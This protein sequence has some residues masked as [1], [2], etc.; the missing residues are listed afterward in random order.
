MNQCL[1]D[2]RSCNSQL[3]GCEGI[4]TTLFSAQISLWQSKP[5]DCLLEQSPSWE[6][7]SHLSSW[8]IPWKKRWHYSRGK[9]DKLKS[10]FSL[11][12]FLNYKRRRHQIPSYARGGGGGVLSCSQDPSSGTC[13]EP[14]EFSQCSHTL[15]NMKFHI[16]ISSALQ[17]PSGFFC[18]D[19]LTNILYAFLS[20]HVCYTP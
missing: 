14:F 17:T 20:F 4:S 3:C 6:A 12:S 9:I 15:L 19:F 11:I 8:V 1:Q 13:S 18:S 16:I 5:K 10:I 7:N 2:T